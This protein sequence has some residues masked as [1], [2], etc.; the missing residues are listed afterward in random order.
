MMRTFYYDPDNRKSP[1]TNHYCCHCHKDI[2]NIKYWAFASNDG[3]DLIHYEDITDL[4][5]VRIAFIGA[6]CVKK[7]DIPNEFYF[8]NE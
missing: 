3:W 7:L 4:K 1:K 5:N 8:K 6:D 2:K